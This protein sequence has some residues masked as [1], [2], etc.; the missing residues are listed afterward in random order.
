MHL[1]IKSEVSMT[2]IAS[3]TERSIKEQK[4]LETAITHEHFTYMCIQ[5]DVY[6]ICEVL[7]MHKCEKI[8]M[9]A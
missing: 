4:W 5:F 3:V 1:C 2:K 7:M 6:I 9:A 8:N